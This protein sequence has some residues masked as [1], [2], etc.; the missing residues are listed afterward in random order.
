MDTLALLN[1]LEKE[2]YD[3][4]ENTKIYYNEEAISVENLVKVSEQEKITL[5]REMYSNNYNSFDNEE[6]NEFA[7]R[8]INE[9]D[10]DNVSLSALK[11]NLLTIRKEALDDLKNESDLAIILGM[12]AIA[13]DSYEFWFNYQDVSPKKGWFSLAIADATGAYGWGAIGA[14]AGPA[15]AIIVGLNGAIINSSGAYIMAQI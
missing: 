12:T 11:S 2:T 5:I 14:I 4:L 9:I 10:K 3:F 13:K 8:I 1:F 7:K 6:V 15:G